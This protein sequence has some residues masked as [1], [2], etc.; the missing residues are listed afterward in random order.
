V[1]IVFSGLRIV[2]EACF[3]SYMRSRHPDLAHEV[4]EAAAALSRAVTRLTELAEAGGFAALP[5]DLLPDVVASLHR[6]RDRVDSV[7][8]TSTALLHRAGILPIATTRWLQSDAGLG[9]AAAASALATGSVLDE[10]YHATR[11]TWLGGEISRD[12]VQAITMAVDRAARAIRHDDQPRFREQAERALLD[13]ARAGATPAD[14]R[15]RARRLRVMIDPEGASRDLHEAH[16]A[17]HLRFV[18]EEDG[19][20]VTGFLTAESHAVVATALG[21]A[22]DAWHR[23]GALPQEDRVEGDDP[24]ARRARRLTAPRLRALA[25]VD[26]CG[27]LLER[28]DLGSHHGAIPRVRVDVDLV[29]L[30]AAFGGTITARDSEAPQV[31]GHESVR[32]ILCDAEISAAITSGARPRCTCGCGC[33]CGVEGGPVTLDDVLL[34]ASKDVLYVK[35]AH[36]VVTPRLRRAIEI[37]EGARCSRPGCGV[38]AWRC[39]AHHIKHWEDGGLTDIS[40]CV[41]VCDRHHHDLHEGGWSLAFTP[42]KRPHEHGYVTWI[43]P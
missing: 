14:I 8:V 3:D 36:R 42:G 25:F 34:E 41:L 10:S 29:D 6:E 12:H 13:Y 11:D 22:I 33:G 2:G 28:G 18:E 7:A 43:P 20:T 38:P 21:Q 24:Q 9:A 37:R 17:Q 16:R 35:R 4:V 5:S 15:R 32:R 1:L 26:L 31:I 40:N 19:V 23:E 39:R 30:T 27:R